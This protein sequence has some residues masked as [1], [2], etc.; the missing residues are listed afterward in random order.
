MLQIL[1][2]F[3]EIKSSTSTIFVPNLKEIKA[4]KIDFTNLNLFLLFFVQRR[5]YEENWVIFKSAYLMNC[6]SDHCQI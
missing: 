2:P 6:W 4:E 5:I 1:S 3:M